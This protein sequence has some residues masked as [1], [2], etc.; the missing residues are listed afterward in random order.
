MELKNQSAERENWVGVTNGRGVQARDV[1][2]TFPA[3]RASL[4]SFGPSGS[5]CFVRTSRHL[6]KEKKMRR[7]KERF[8]AVVRY[9]PLD[10]QLLG[11]LGGA[12]LARDIVVHPEVYLLE[13]GAEPRTRTTSS[14][15]D[16]DDAVQTQE[17]A[18]GIPLES[19]QELHG[20]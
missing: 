2:L 20:E 9:G 19:G 18:K 14:V 4:A 11:E 5:P 8:A 16:V 12:L 15:L 10:S 1:S 6:A 3:R 13:P 7:K 17:S